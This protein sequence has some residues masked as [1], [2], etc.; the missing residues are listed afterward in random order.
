MNAPT[1]S[2]VTRAVGAVGPPVITAHTWNSGVI[3]MSELFLNR[4]CTVMNLDPETVTVVCAPSSKTPKVWCAVIHPDPDNRLRMWVRDFLPGHDT[5]FEGRPAV[6][7]L[8]LPAGI[9]EARSTRTARESQTVVFQ[10]DEWGEI[11]ILDERGDVDA[12][13]AAI[14]GWTAGQL[15]DARAEWVHDYPGP[16]LE[17]TPRQIAYAVEIRDRMLMRAIRAGDRDLAAL[18]RGV[19]VASWVIANR[20]RTHGE[21]WEVFRREG[22]GPNTPSRRAARQTEGQV[23]RRVPPSGRTG[24]TDLG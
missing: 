3:L 8:D 2:I 1:V 18:L 13:I 9:F 23:A 22:W 7:F 6:L 17:G 4:E 14:N 12:V 5:V 16:P 10:V 15:S 11:E 24:P 19:R 20:L 21:L